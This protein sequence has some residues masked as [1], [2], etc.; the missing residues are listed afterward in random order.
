MRTKLWSPLYLTVLASLAVGLYTL[1]S[2]GQ[3]LFF[4]EPGEPPVPAVPPAPVTTATAQLAPGEIPRAGVSGG[5]IRLHAQAAPAVDVV[6]APQPVV[7]GGTIRLHATAPNTV[8][9][10]AGPQLAVSSDAFA[11]HAQHVHLTGADEETRKLYADDQALEH[12]T[13]KLL[14]QLRDAESAGDRSD[15]LE[16]VSQTVEQ[17]FGI[18]Q[19]IRAKELEALEARVR[20]LRELHDKREE[21]KAD[22]IARR[23]EELTR[24]AEGLGWS[25]GEYASVGHDFDFAVP[26]PPAGPVPRP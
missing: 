16:Q 11:V 18:R 2:V 15:L 26:P 8:G 9:L 13:R 24:A 6:A 17:Q 3:E 12:E 1:S 5:T 10:V 19:Q 4:T 7:S 20:K 21:A 23:I 14:E 25:G 22:I